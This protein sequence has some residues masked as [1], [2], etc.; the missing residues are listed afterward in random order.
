MKRGIFPAENGIVR[1][2]LLREGDL[3]L[4][5]AWRNQDTIRRWFF[6][7][8]PIRPDQ[9][10][11]WF[12]QYLERDDDFVF[13]I[14]EVN[15]GYRPVGQVALYHIDWPAKR[16]E[17]GRLMIG[18]PSAR[19]KGLARSATGL[20]L[21]IGFQILGLDEIYLEVFADNT[22]AIRVYQDSRFQVDEVHD[23]IMRMTLHR[24]QP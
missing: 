18:D 11:G 5:L 6:N 15:T 12:R 22:P 24:P 1:L 20:V 7:S 13:I 8:D 9:H 14:E 3:P 16:A 4:T 23:N 19:G 2:R 21:E 17:Y 10:A